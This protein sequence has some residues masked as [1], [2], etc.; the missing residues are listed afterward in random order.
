MRKSESVC[1]NPCF[2]NINLDACEILMLPTLAT[3]SFRG[4]KYA[5]DVALRLSSLGTDPPVK[6]WTGVVLAAFTGN[7]SL[8]SN[9]LPFSS[10]TAVPLTDCT[11]CTAVLQF[12]IPA[13]LLNCSGCVRVL[14][15]PAFSNFSALVSARCTFSNARFAFSVRS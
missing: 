15:P 9:V 12:G 1:L 14:N 2:C 5:R 10:L 13:R 3:I 8:V 7:T 6:T 4:C 11:V